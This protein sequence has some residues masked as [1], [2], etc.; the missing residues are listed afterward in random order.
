[1]KTNQW[2]IS[3]LSCTYVIKNHD[4]NLK[5]CKNS[6]RMF[7]LIRKTSFKIILSQIHKMK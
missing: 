6:S 1:M 5:L 3:V 2:L 4:P 7:N